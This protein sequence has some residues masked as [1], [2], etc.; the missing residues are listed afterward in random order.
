MRITVYGIKVNDRGVLMRPGVYK[1]RE[2]AKDKAIELAEEYRDKWLKN[3]PDEDDYIDII[4]ER[5]DT[6]VVSS[7]VHGYLIRYRAVAMDLH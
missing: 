6:I 4:E 1:S 3:H 5:L 2:D 7:I